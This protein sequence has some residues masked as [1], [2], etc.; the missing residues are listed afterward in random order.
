MSDSA[1]I[2]SQQFKIPFQAGSFLRKLG[3][4]HDDLARQRVMGAQILEIGARSNSTS[5]CANRR[6]ISECGDS[7]AVGISVIV[8]QPP[9][10]RLRSFFTG[11]K[12]PPR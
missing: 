12:A 3:A 2:L 5:N 10:R 11:D 1:R 6:R 4:A 8:T 9:A 7:D